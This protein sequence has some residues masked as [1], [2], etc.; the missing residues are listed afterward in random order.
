MG[1]DG[2]ALASLG[3]ARAGWQGTAAQGNLQKADLREAW[4]LKER[5][6]RTAV[7][8]T[9]RVVVLARDLDMTDS[10]LSLSSTACR[11]LLLLLHGLPNGMAKST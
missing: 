6:M 9:C 3:L 1:Y 10:L 5:Y 4:S 11:V 7:H 2:R 8:S